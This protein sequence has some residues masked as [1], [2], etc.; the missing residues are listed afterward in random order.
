MNIPKTFLGLQKKFYKL[1]PIHN[2]DD[3]ERAMTAAEDLSLCTMLTS[4][5]SDYLHVLVM[6]I[7]EYENKQMKE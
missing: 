7:A 3:Y 5:Q 6:I 1:R 4:D 2:K